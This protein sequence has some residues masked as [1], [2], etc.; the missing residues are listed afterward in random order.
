M[1]LQVSIRNI[2][3]VCTLPDKSFMNILVTGASRGI[4][5][6]LVKYYAASGA[7]T[8]FVVSRNSARLEEL[9]NECLSIS[10]K[11]RLVV[12]PFS[13]QDNKS[14]EKIHAAV[15]GEVQHLDVVINNAGLLV[16]KP[17]AAISSDE[18][19]AVYTVNVLGPFQMM[20]GLLPF[21]GGEKGSHIVN[22][23]SMGGVQGSVKFPGLS[24]YSSSKMAIAGLTECL[25]EE[26]KEKN[27]CV[28]CLALGAVQTEMLEE[29]FPGYKAM[30][31]PHDMAE[32]IG[33][34]SLKAQR[35]ING[36]IIPVALST[37]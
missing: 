18:L 28:N 10:S 15:K 2:I 27:I 6:D 37:P 20:Q 32:Y 21:L 36:K 14:F 34:F 33:D 31:S 5:Y 1:S 29:A 11:L 4:G 35:Y 23:G 19:L 17:F 26:L 24:A 22:I 7:S 12:L 30:C 13:L 25:A 16:N 8:I 3:K 9:R